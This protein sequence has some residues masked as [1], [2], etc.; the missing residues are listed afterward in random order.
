MKL[1]FFFLC[2]N[3]SFASPRLDPNW[4]SQ[5]KAIDLSKNVKK[6][7]DSILQAQGKA[8]DKMDSNFTK[9]LPYG[10]VMKEMVSDFAVSKSGLLGLSALKSNNGVEV[11]WK[12]ASTFKSLNAEVVD[13]PSIVIEA[14]P[15]EKDLDQVAEVITKIVKSSG[16]VQESRNLKANI[17]D[18]LLGINANLKNIQVTKLNN[19]K[20]SG[21]RLDLNFSV[22]GGVWLF[23]K[24]GIA[25]RVRMEWKLKEASL[26]SLKIAEATSETRFM[27]KTLDALE[28]ALQSTQLPGFKAKKISIGVGASQKKSL[29]GLWKYSNGFIGYI[30]FVPVE[31]FN[32][33]LFKD[34]VPSELLDEPFT[35]GG[36]E[37]EVSSLKGMPIISNGS[38]TQRDFV[39][40]MEKSLQTASFFA[41]SAQSNHSK[42]WSIAEIKTINDISYTGF[43]GLADFTTK[44]AL[45]I[46]F[47]RN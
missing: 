32:K 10:F 42:G 28:K 34:V 9:A 24:P 16:K 4:V 19:W 22:N 8:L 46:D 7:F 44:G 14:A 43:F 38:F 5:E 40:G 6:S 18:S 27:L 12:R 45:E 31:S 33:A 2:I 23:V 1:L 11:K 39:A 41:S 17:K 35:I 13:E 25:L 29:F 47:K 20:T 15:T 30:S 37:N 21:V 26:G 3:V 36:I